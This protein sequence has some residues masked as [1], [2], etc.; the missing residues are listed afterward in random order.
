MTPPTANFVQLQ[1]LAA[2]QMRSHQA[3]E[4]AANPKLPAC[5]VRADVNSLAF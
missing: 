2:A 4:T 3:C 1:R 5:A